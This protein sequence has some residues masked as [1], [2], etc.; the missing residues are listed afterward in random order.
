MNRDRQRIKAEVQVAWM[1]GKDKE[2]LIQHPFNPRMERSEDARFIVSQLWII[3]V[4]LPIVLGIVLVI[5][6]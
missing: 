6:K 4:L 1:S 2:Y 3:F 5:I